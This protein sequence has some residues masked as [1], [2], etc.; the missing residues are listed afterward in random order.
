[1]YT[2]RKC[3]FENEMYTYAGGKI[4]TRSLAVS[5]LQMRFGHYILFFFRGA[6]R[7][8]IIRRDC[9]AL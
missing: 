9:G 8:K 7:S 3:A 6:H 4:K 5:H 1:M 2:A